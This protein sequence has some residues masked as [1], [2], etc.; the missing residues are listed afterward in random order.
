MYKP[1]HVS[2]AR[3]N[4]KNNDIRFSLLNINKD[5]YMFGDFNINLSDSCFNNHHT[6][7]FKFF[8]S[9]SFIPLIHK[10]TRIKNNYATYIDYIFT[11]VSIEQIVVSGIL[12]TQAY[13][14]HFP[15]LPF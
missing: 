8:F 9:N 6:Q 4:E 15:I 5:V 13:S 14:D 7:E 1:P 3:F 11:N 12:A 2:I 10:P